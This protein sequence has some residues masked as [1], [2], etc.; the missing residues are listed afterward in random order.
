[1]SEKI[2]R[3]TEENRCKRQVPATQP[4]PPPPST[5]PPRPKRKR[6]GPQTPPA[7][8]AADGYLPHTN[9]MHSLHAGMETDPAQ[10]APSTS[11]TATGPASRH[12]GTD[13]GWKKVERKRKGKR[14]KEKEVR[15]GTIYVT[16]FIGGNRNARP[17]KARKPRKGSEVRG[18]RGGRKSGHVGPF[19]GELS[20]ASGALALHYHHSARNQE[21]R[22]HQRREEAH[23][24]TAA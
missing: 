6:T 8:E 18:K 7:G 11:A 16:V 23:Q 3:L 22:S 13:K 1:M 12:G 20:S 9:L 17:H 10:P 5:P 4:L 15:G 14:K 21:A 2:D 19:R 24:D